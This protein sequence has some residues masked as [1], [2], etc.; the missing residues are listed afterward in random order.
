MGKKSGFKPGGSIAILPKK[1][2]LKGE[3][4]KY[5]NHN[6]RSL[7]DCQL[8]N[9][10]LKELSYYL[11]DNLNISKRAALFDRGDLWEDLK[12]KN[13]TEGVIKTIARNNYV[14]RISN[15]YIYVIRPLYDSCHDLFLM[16]YVH[17]YGDNK[18]AIDKFYYT[19]GAFLSMNNLI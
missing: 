6:L 1:T 7:I 18:E 2:T 11:I 4:M 15:N 19:I 13:F 3:K 17:K 10:D 16:H 8:S 9:K 12:Y 5:T 14:Y